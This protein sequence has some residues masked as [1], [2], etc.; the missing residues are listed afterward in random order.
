MK[1]LLMTFGSFPASSRFSPPMKLNSLWGRYV[2]YTVSIKAA[3]RLM[4][5]SDVIN[6]TQDKHQG[7]M[8]I[9]HAG[10]KAGLETRG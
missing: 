7:G 1:L 10:P 3:W 5:K 4:A 9:V 2:S 8:P 6:I